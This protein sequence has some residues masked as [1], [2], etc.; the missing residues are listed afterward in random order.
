M[1]IPNLNREAFDEEASNIV[2]Q[3]LFTNIDHLKAFVAEMT[4]KGYEKEA[5]AGISKIENYLWQDEHVTFQAFDDILKTFI[6]LYLP[7]PKT[8][9]PVQDLACSKF[10]LT[11]FFD[12]ITTDDLET[13]KG[14]MN[15]LIGYFNQN[16]LCIKC[17]YITLF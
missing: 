6:D 10:L 16:R 5:L 9:R 11:H 1:Y 12:K 2:G 4:K 7:L 8:D 14:N 13:Y 3:I 15:P 17:K